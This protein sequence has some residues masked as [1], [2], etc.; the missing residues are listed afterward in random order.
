MTSTRL[1][2]GSAFEVARLSTMRYQGL[3]SLYVISGIA[4]TAAAQIFLKRGAGHSFMAPPWLIYT[5]LSVIFYLAS[6]VLYLLALRH[7]EISTISP[8]MMA[9]IVSII[10]LYG[11]F[12]GEHYSFA[13]LAGI[14]LAIVS[15]VLIAASR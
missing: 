15:I 6:F 1:R 4:V 2:L 8:I 14:G 3:P 5:V 13:K 7:F 9:S 12:S 10:A 11:F